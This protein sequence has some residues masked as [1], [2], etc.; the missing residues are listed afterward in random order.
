MNVNELPRFK[1]RDN[2]QIVHAGQIAFMAKDDANKTLMVH[3]N[4]E[5]LTQIVAVPLSYL[6]SCHPVIG[7]YLVADADGNLSYSHPATFHTDFNAVTDDPEIDL[8]AADFSDALMWLKEG[9]SVS[10]AG[11]NAG[12]QFVYLVKGEQLAASLGYGFG[13]CIGEP[14]FSDTFVLRNAQNRLVTWVPSLGDL[15]AT[16]WCLFANVSPGG[17]E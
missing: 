10:R 13:E 4:P 8:D 9:K 2:G 5:N 15:L 17:D 6:S 7:G 16:D 1:R 11:W 3:P 12:G 14:T